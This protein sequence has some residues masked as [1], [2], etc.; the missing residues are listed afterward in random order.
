[1]L[2]TH[3]TSPKPTQLSTLNPKFSDIASARASPSP[4]SPPLA[5]ELAHELAHEL[6]QSS[7]PTAPN[8]RSSPPRRGKGQKGKKDTEALPV[9]AAKSGHVTS[10]SA[11]TEPGRTSV[12]RE[13]EKKE[14]RDARARELEESRGR[15]R[16]AQ[17][18]L[19]NVAN[20][21]AEDSK[22]GGGGG[23]GG[24]VHGEGEGGVHDTGAELGVGA[25]VGDD[26]VAGPGGGAGGGARARVGWGE[27]TPLGNKDLEND[28]NDS[29]PD[30]SGDGF[31]RGEKG[32]HATANAAKTGNT[33]I[34]TKKNQVKQSKWDQETAN[35]ANTGDTTN[36]QNGNKKKACM[37]KEEEVCMNTGNSA[38]SQN[39]EEG[40]DISVA[41]LHR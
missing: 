11:R 1:M 40:V 22:Q 24:G 29:L 3:A 18:K 20:V 23:G 28:E 8:P 25:D 14:Q 41:G 39:G 17:R 36:V 9:D 13:V 35:A 34:E 27:A 32:D 26:G 37:E 15:V 16:G 10:L 21:A 6:V 33:A 38:S 2:L 12:T 30:L 19:F 7:L 5:R 4:P 31:R